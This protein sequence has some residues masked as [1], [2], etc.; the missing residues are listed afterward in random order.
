MH[1]FPV[2]HAGFHC[3]T[4]FLENHL[5]RSPR[6]YLHELSLALSDFQSS[7]FS[8][9]CRSTSTFPGTFGNDQL[10]SRHTQVA[11]QCGARLILSACWL[12]RTRIAI[13]TG[14]SA[15]AASVLG[16][17]RSYSSSYD[18]AGHA[19]IVWLVMPFSG[20]IGYPKMVQFSV[21]PWQFTSVYHIM[22]HHVPCKEG[23]FPMV[24]HIKN[25]QTWSKFT[26]LRIA[27]IF[28]LHLAGWTVAASTDH[29]NTNYNH[30]SI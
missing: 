14:S 20:K 25:G 12:S 13:A 21:A 26:V 15:Y 24:F 28:L 19:V 6:P 4:W 8:R 11:P 5:I 2:E 10:I 30:R 27:H 9:T 23:A 1:S 22:F 3:Y 29:T 7:A 17:G 18:G 16:D